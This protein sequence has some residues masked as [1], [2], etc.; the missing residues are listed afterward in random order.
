MRQ[1]KPFDRKFAMLGSGAS[2]YDRA[3]DIIAIHVSILERQLPRVGVTEYERRRYG[4]W[5]HAAG[6]YSN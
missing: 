5:S 6:T 3:C 4:T 1:S 2:G